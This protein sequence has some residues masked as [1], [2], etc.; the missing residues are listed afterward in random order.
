MR[1]GWQ[2]FVHQSLKGATDEP[3]VRLLRE[4]VRSGSNVVRVHLDD[5]GRQPEYR[6]LLSLHR[7]LSEM[8]VPHSDSF[9]RWSL[10]T[11]TRLADPDEE[12]RRFA[13]LLRERF[14]PLEQELGREYFDS[15]LGEQLR[16]LGPPRA[17]ARL[18]G[19]RLVYHPYS[20]VADGRARRKDLERIES[21]L[22]S[23]A[24]ELGSSLKYSEQEV[25]EL[26]DA[27]LE[28]SLSERYL[29]DVEDVEDV[30]PL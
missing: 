7:Q 2:E 23:L 15:L 20:G 6:V 18:D 10:E 14:E 30:P 27:A 3:H 11:G 28:H 13:L 19:G 8:R 12:A 4:R 9:T 1:Q 17:R 25:A 29:P 5:S 22:A 26:L 21:V 24:R 16:G